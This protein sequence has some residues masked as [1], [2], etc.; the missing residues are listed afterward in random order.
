MI[1]VLMM[2]YNRENMVSCAIESV[3]AQTYKDFE[4]VIV[5]HG[6]TDRSGDIAEEY[7]K[8]DGRIR[9]IHSEPG[10]IGQGR[11]IAIE[12]ARGDYI[13]YIDDDDTFEPDILEFLLNLILDNDADISICGT[14]EKSSYED[15]LVMT[16]EDALIEM[17]WRKK[18]TIRCSAKMFKSGIVKKYKYPESSKFDDIA[19]NY[20]IFADAD[21][22]AYHG[23]PKYNICRHEGNESSWTKNPQLLNAEILDEY[24][25]AY[26]TR[27][28]YLSARF[29]NS[30]AAFEYF[31]WSFMIS[32]VEK[33]NRFNITGC[34]NQLEYMMSVLKEH[35]DT[36]LNYPEIQPFER[37]WM[38][39]YIYKV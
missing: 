29:P 39:R 20:K 10:T 35:S 15:K 34:Q 24:L 36:F 32:M 8:K 11:N 9:V 25:D 23:L 14:S 31:R 19:V 37:E 26:N 21:R 17:M 12:A 27:T 2:T 5:D 33:I 13:T 3:L 28:E 1:S 16:A 4:Y 7:A 30:S 6:S 18:Y 22:V 38:E